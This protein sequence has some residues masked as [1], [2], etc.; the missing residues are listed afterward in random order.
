MLHS[1]IQLLKSYLLNLPPCYLTTPPQTQPTSEPPSQPTALSYAEIN[2]PILR[3]IQALVNRLPLLIPSDQESFQQES[4]AEKSD[5]SLVEMLGTLGRSVKD[6][7]ELGAKFAVVETARQATK[8][9]GSMSGTIDPS[10]LGSENG[11]GMG[12]DGYVM[13]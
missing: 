3:S 7:K 4:L 12:G 2:H 8:K 11:L 10:F 9:G 13:D 5:V 1:R 6:A